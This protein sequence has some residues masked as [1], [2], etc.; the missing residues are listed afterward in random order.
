MLA[1]RFA[2][3]AGRYHATP[4]GKQVNEGAPEWPPSPWRIL[5]AIV[6]TWRR[7]LPDL[8]PERVVPIVE[9][10]AS[11]FP[12]FRLPEAAT[13]HTRHFMPLYAAGS[14]TQV[15]DS[16]VAVDAKDAVVAAWPHVVLDAARRRDLAAILRN[17]P[18]LGRAESWIEASLVAEDEEC[19]DPNAFALEAGAL[20][21]DDYEIV[22]VLTPRAS[23]G[24]R[25]LEVETSA[26]RRDGRMEP[27]GAQWYPYVR[28]ADC[29]SARRA[30]AGAASWGARPTVVRF[31][32]AASQRPSHLETLRWGERARM[33]AM[34]R[35]GKQNSGTAS[36]ALSGKDE[37]GAPLQEGHRHAFYVPTDEDGDGQLD[38]LTVWAPMGLDKKELSA[39]V[40]IKKLHSGD[41]RAPVQLVY[42]AHGTKADFAAVTPLFGQAKRWR[43]VTPYVLSR[44]V[45]WRGP[46]GS[47]RM[48]DAPEEQIRREFS[49]RCP[50]APALT[51]VKIANRREP[52]QPMK[53]GRSSE[54]R[55]FEFKTY[56][57]GG[58]YAGGA[59]NFQ[60]EFESEISGPLL[61]GFA[62]H[63]GLGVFIPA[64]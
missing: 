4:W 48:V 45:K 15:I 13:G 16:F 12:K 47:K 14:S 25:E 26:L 52:I 22:R 28:K 19:L 1:I 11:E 30:S 39:L 44:H 36:P 27:E 38:H 20:P 41:Q 50:G 51:E 58:S 60:I 63:F 37:T 32:M 49:R 2:F 64:A 62:C 10:L 6:A 3:T 40:S 33:S 53:K 54:Y 21:K 57:R 35:Y 18:Y 31:A 7:T 42:Q 9:A 43:S 59:F 24:L 46:K 8:P 34:S 23:V 61:L 55:S 56:R 29:F 5:R 17:M